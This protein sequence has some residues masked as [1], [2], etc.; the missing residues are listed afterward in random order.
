MVNF[1]P[2]V[3][4]LETINISVRGLGQVVVDP[5]TIVVGNTSVVARCRIDGVRGWR[6]IKCYTTS[7]YC[8]D[9][10]IDSLYPQSLMVYTFRGR[11]E[12]VDVSIGKWID[13]DAL[14]V[15]LYRGG[16]DFVALSRAFD[17]MALAH[18]QRG[19]VHCDIKPEN[20]IVR[21]DGE[22]ELIDASSVGSAA[23]GNRYG[24]PKFR[25]RYRSLRRTDK[26]TDHYPLSL[27]SAMLAALVH[28]PYF[29]H[30]THA[31]DEY[32]ADA[33]RILR[34]NDDAGHYNIIVAMQTS[35]MGKIEGIE[36][37]FKSVVVADE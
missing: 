4:T 33:M 23:Q 12:Y 14:D 21:P 6:A 37:L 22:M 9:E 15:V 18:L 25:H 5:A 30:E 1:L 11:E 36:E 24:T 31:M 34:D 16:C 7:Q 3:K 20:I 8:G 10:S 29:L 17:R 32:I 27:I 35:V 28:D 19:A 13:G 26:H 2:I